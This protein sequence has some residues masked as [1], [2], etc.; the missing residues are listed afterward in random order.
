MVLGE[1]NDTVPHIKARQKAE[2]DA[3]A[4]TTQWP[5]RHPEEAGE[6]GVNHT[7]HSRRLLS[8]TMR[9]G[10]QK[11]HRTVKCPEGW[12]HGRHCLHWN[13][14]SEV[15]VQDEEEM[16]RKKTDTLDSEY[17]GTERSFILFQKAGKVS[18]IVM[19]NVFYSD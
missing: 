17:R 15:T 13:G 4:M 2:T 10:V 1:L 19:G 18:A 11:Q 14:G 16:V 6:G 3:R 12:L 5:E 8:M 7:M 9:G